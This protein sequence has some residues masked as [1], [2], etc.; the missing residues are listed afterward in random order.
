MEQIKGHMAK[1]HT[2]S[3]W[4]KKNNCELCKKSFSNWTLYEVH[5]KKHQ[6]LR[7]TCGVCKLEFTTK[8][9]GLEHKIECD[10]VKTFSCHECNFKAPVENYISKHLDEVYMAGFETITN[11]ENS[12]KGNET[13][14]KCFCPL[15]DFKA[16]TEEAVVKHLE[17]THELKDLYIID[18]HCRTGW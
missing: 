18:G 8:A 11:I 6:C 17:E 3:I 7:F 1:E 9:S 12:I 2:D 5:I 13:D 16:Q 15:C 4:H 14:D 10:K